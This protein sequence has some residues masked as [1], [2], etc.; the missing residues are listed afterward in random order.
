MSRDPYYLKILEEDAERERK[1]EAS[2]GIFG[3][4][5]DNPYS[6]CAI[7]SLLVNTCFWIGIGISKLL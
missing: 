1:F 5:I 7:L 3:R 2:L 6:Y 4:L